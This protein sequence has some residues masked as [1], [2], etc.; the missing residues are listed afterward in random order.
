MNVHVSMKLDWHGN[1]FRAQLINEIHRAIFKACH[2]FRVQLQSAIGLW[3]SRGGNP[4]VWAKSSPVGRPPY[5]QTGNLFN[6]IK[7][8]IQSDP[9]LNEYKGFVYT[10]VPYAPDLE[11]GGLSATYPQS[12]KKYTHV[13]L[14]KSPFKVGQLY[15]I[16]RRPAWL[17]VF[18]KEWQTMAQFFAQ[19][20]I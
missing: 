5:R 14:I 3:G 12:A 11:F 10:D 6:S 2:H 15:Y 4:R 17:P 13:R 8:S 16:R 18:A 1:T 9:G 19:I 7:V 20:R